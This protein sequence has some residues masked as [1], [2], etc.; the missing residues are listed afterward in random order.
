MFGLPSLS[1][2]IVLGL[3]VAAVWYG[4]KFISRLDAQRKADA[5]AGKRP[6]RKQKAEAE[7]E[8]ET[9]AMV[10]CRQC[11]AYV[12]ENGKSSCEHEGCPML[13]SRR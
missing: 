9:V 11:G 5:A 8:A 6:A 2:L 13:I 3:V 4:F 12:P 10:A 1:K 7:P